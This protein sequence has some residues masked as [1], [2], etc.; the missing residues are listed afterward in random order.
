[1]AR[2]PL[3][4]DT[5]DLCP[6]RLIQQR[7]LNGVLGGWI[8]FEINPQLQEVRLRYTLPDGTLQDYE[9]SLDVTP[10][11]FGGVRW[12]IRCWCCGSRRRALYLAPGRPL[13]ACRLCCR[14]GYRTQVLRPVQR[15]ALAAK[16]L[17]VRYPIQRPKGMWR[18]KHLRGLLAR[19]AAEQA[20]S[21]HIQANSGTARAASGTGRLITG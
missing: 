4:E 14:L 1:M 10:C 17:S 8:G 11:N 7:A 20:L 19:A 9:L 18:I 3:V 16:K 21:S 12:W 5:L 6:H 2:K 15:A 13:F